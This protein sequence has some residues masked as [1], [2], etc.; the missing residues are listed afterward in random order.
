MRCDINNPDQYYDFSEVRIQHPGI[1][2]RSLLR[3]AR[4]PS[5]GWAGSGAP[6]TG[7]ASGVRKVILYNPLGD[8]LREAHHG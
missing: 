8:L 5:C 4:W 2:H 1:L 7:L 3:A 6:A